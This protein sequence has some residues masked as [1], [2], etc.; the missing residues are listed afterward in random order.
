MILRTLRYNL[1]TD[2]RTILPGRY[3]V[4]TVFPIPTPI[5]VYGVAETGIAI[6][7]NIVTNPHGEMEDWFHYSKNDKCM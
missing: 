3:A 2:M 7:M 4:P 5:R 1:H 6:F